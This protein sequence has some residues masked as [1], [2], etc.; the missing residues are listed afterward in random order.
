MSTVFLSGS[1]KISRL[2]EDVI[3]RLQ[4]IID[5]GL[6]VII[7]DANGADKAFQKFFADANYKNVTVFCSG[8]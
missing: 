4:N 3:V 2:S 5:S 8:N 1:R 6:K 7:G